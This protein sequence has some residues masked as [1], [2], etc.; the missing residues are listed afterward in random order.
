M[1]VQF[2]PEHS[3]TAT[4]PTEAAIVDTLK[5]DSDRPELRGDAQ[6]GR[7]LLESTRSYANESVPQSW[8]HVI[9]IFV[10]VIATLTGAG[11]APWWPL[12]AVL[13]L[14]GCLLM[15][16]MFITYHDFMHGA[17]LRGSR[18]A[19]VL[20][21]VY[22]AF[23]LTPARSW[24]KSHNHHHGH[25]GQ[26]TTETVGAFPLISTS[27]WHK[28]SRKY[29]ASYRASRHPLIVLFGYVTIF[30]FCITLLPLL[31]EPTKHWDSALSILAH[32]GLIAVLSIF[33]GFDSAFFAFLLPMFLSS[34]FGGY[35]FFAQHS[36]R[37]MRVL[38]PEKW[39]FYRGAVLS[40][41][42]LRLNKVM[43]WLTG[44]IGYHH[45][46]HV[47]VRIP[48]YRLA[49][50]MAAIPALRNPIV[51]SLS[52]SE[53]VGAFRSSLWDE[54]RGRMVSYREARLND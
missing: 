18:L 28:A 32:G 44:S 39:T 19:S 23:A 35:L 25:V 14:A 12:Q 16:R 2:I 49:E 38:S 9:T 31:R 5:D 24:R 29:R 46:H 6:L 41:N 43:T 27:M 17:I 52:L 13:A 8:R 20:F 26:L 47:N 15:V 36:F 33:G 53:V 4:F 50:A 22:G 11:M 48:F 21:N 10:L 1:G 34:I 40:S 54:K 51:T 45:V 30:A 37:S 3:V 42:F 7:D